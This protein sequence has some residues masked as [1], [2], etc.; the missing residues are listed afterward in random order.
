MFLAYSF[1]AS[2]SCAFTELTLDGLPPHTAKAHT[3]LHL[4]S[5]ATKDNVAL[6]SLSASAG[7]NVLHHASSSN[8]V[9]NLS[10][11]SSGN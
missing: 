6:M 3:L 11:R 4:A 9:L 2:S 7:V 8:C 10:C 5:G 1:L